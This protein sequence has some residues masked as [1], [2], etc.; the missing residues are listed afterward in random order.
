MEDDYTTPLRAGRGNDLLGLNPMN[1]SVEDEV[2]QDL[3][4]AQQN[5]HFNIRNPSVKKSHLPNNLK[6]RELEEAQELDRMLEQER[7]NLS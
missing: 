1:Y 6:Q 2:Q 5:R 3:L 4:A 7:R